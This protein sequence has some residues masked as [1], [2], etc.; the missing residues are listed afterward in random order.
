MLSNIKVIGLDADD[1]LW[2]NEPYFRDAEFKL[3][4]LLKPFAPDTDIIAALFNTEMKILKL[5]GYGA[6]AF[7]LSL[8][9]TAVILSGY[10]VHASVINDIIEMGRGLMNIPIE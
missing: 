7:T 3:A 9:E 1:T 4:E 2:V 8:I 5:Y 10:R 6:K